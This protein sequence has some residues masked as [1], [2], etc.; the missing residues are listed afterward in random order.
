MIDILKFM[1]LEGLL[2]TFIAILIAIVQLFR[3]IVRKR[4]NLSPLS[5][6]NPLVK[7]YDDVN[8]DKY[9][10]FFR[11]LGL[12]IGMTTILA[13]FEYPT[14]HSTLMTWE[15]TFKF[16]NEEVDSAFVLPKPKIQLPKKAAPIII[17]EVDD[18]KDIT[19]EV[20]IFIPEDFDP[21]EV[22]E[23]YVSIDEIEEKPE[24]DFVTFAEQS[25]SY[26]GGMG[27][28][29]KWLGKKIKYPSQAKRMGVE[30]KVFVEFIVERDGALS[31]LKVVRGIG[32]GCDQEAIRILKMCPNWTPGKQRGRPVR[33]KMVLPISFRLQ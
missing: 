31:N 18:E 15:D 2:F 10:Q 3:L 29:Y 25:A 6:S 30:G 14:P 7:K 1:G 21:G 27:K 13:A 26:K 22:I 19:T 24:D 16:E 32:A 9:T 28:F 17:I 5:K 12:C 8:L 23:E 4:S 11:M 20:D 33:Q